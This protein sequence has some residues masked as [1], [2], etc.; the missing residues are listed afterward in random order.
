[1]ERPHFLNVLRV[2]NIPDGID[3]QENLIYQVRNRTA[4]ALREPLDEGRGDKEKGAK[5]KGKRGRP[6]A[7]KTAAPKPTDFLATN[8][9]AKDLL[10]EETVIKLPA[11]SKT[12]A[13]KP[14]EFL[15]TIKAAKDLLGEETVIKL[16]KDA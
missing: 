7:S 13:P 12:A 1:M 10:G 9:A 14:T 8:K 2:L 5:P 11:A 4:K 16:V 15:A 3:V 6:A